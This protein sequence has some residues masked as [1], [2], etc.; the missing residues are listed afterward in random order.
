VKKFIAFLLLFP[1]AA[2]AFDQALC[3]SRME[4]PAN[5]T[6][7]L[8]SSADAFLAGNVFIGKVYGYVYEGEIKKIWTVKRDLFHWGTTSTRAEKISAGQGFS[9]G[10]SIDATLFFASLVMKANTGDTGAKV[11]FC[12]AYLNNE[13]AEDAF[14]NLNNL[15]VQAVKR[16]RACIASLKP[17]LD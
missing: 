4:I 11:C 14:K 17:I 9:I 8:A 1:S 15:Y 5:S 2:A 3:Q 13:A 10:S 12:N 16:Q 7:S 6:V